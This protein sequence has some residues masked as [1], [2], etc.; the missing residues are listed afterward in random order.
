VV[1]ASALLALIIGAAFTELLFAVDALRDAERRARQTEQV[2]ASSN[3]LERLLLDLETGE[4]GFVLT[5]QE[6]FLEPWESARVAFPRR[7]AVLLALVAGQGATENAARKI[8]QRQLS[9]IRD[10]SVPTVNAVRRGDPSAVSVATTAAGKLRV[11]AM[12]RDFDNLFAA[13][14]A[15]AAASTAS[16]AT[17]DRRA[18]AAAIIGVV[19][20]IVLI[21]LYAGYLTRAI[22]RPVR[23]AAAMAGRLADG[24]LAARLPE[25]EVAEIGALARAFNVMGRSLEQRRDELAALA[26]EQAALRRVATLVARG[27]SPDEVFSAV[28]AELAHLLD[29]SLTTILRFEP[30]GT[31]T[32]VG[33]WSVPG[34]DI[35]IGKRLTLLG[36]G[37]A[38]QVKETGQ[39]ARTDRF[40]GAPG[41]VPDWVH[42]LG[43]RS[44]VGSPIIVDGVLWGAA[45]A[46]FTREGAPPPRTESRLLDFT[47]LAATA[48]A[49]AEAHAKLMASRA[50]VVAT[51]D[52]TRRRIERDLH[53]GAQQRLVSL[54]LQLR[55]AEAAVPPGLEELATELERVA[56]GLDGALDELREL[57]RGIHPAVLA[58]GGLRSALKNL[59]RRSAVPVE[60]DVRTAGRLPKAVEVGAYYVVAEALTNAARHARAST[61]AV[62][63]EAGDDVVRVRVCDDGVGGADLARG[64]GLIGLKDRVE[65]LGGRIALESEPGAG[66]VL[67]VELPLAAGAAAALSE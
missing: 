36:A 49:N 2:I 6:R 52:E 8:A 38:V 7:A 60:L 48:I 28:A 63:V 65:A 15:T 40:A 25:T 57:A 24:D 3:A 20:S 46:A 11:D 51:A 62:H 54:V 14:R 55:S 31:A 43:V 61:V 59:A 27:A 10:Y 35:P 42:R 37:I 4:R 21:A 26:E 50:R 9:Y 39:P 30:D 17:A 12:R 53:D 5:R 13:E 22:V 56:D 1:V 64:T 45:V 18:S 23:R 67:S 16:A 41:S 33:R 44:G 66:T 47:E 32:I 19:G 29:A 58:E 34:A